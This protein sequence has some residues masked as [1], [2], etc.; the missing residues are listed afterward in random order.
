MSTTKGFLTI[1]IGLLWHEFVGLLSTRHWWRF[2]RPLRFSSGALREIHACL[3]LWKTPYKKLRRSHFQNSRVVHAK[4][5]PLNWWKSYAPFRLSA[6][7]L[8][9]KRTCGEDSKHCGFTVVARDSWALDFTITMERAV[10]TRFVLFSGH[11][12]SSYS[13]WIVKSQ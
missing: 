2:L 11:R 7:I 6:E 5:F 13:E 8:D 10:R 3:F 9:H 1:D 4:C 12:L